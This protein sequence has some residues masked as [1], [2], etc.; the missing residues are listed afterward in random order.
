MTN[1][2]AIADLLRAGATYRRISDELHVSEHTIAEVR[3][4][5]RIPIPA[6]RRGRRTPE[7]QR[8]RDRAVAAMLR[9]GATRAE[10]KETLEVSYS[11]IT[12]VRKAQ[13]IPL[14]PG[15]RGRRTR[16]QQEPDA[17]TVRRHNH[18]A[19]LLRAGATY[20]QVRAETSLSYSTISDIR[21]TRRIRLRRRSAHTPDNEPRKD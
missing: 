16:P 17:E 7:Q 21:K 10:V 14:P 8:A 5:L 18:A 19:Q 6:G 3:E 13:R 4:T 15:R 12:A 1:R 2:T 20:D 9:A 11:V